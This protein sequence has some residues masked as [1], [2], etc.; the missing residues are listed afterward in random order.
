MCIS[1]YTHILNFMN[2]EIMFKLFKLMS[3]LF[4]YLK[5]NV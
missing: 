2:I 3:K 4:S 1:V 5:K